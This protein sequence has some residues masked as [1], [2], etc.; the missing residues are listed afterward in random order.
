MTSA[1]HNFDYIPENQLTKFTLL[2]PR[3]PRPCHIWPVP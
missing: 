3:G 1:S 2:N